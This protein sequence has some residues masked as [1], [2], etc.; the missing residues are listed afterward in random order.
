MSDNEIIEIFG[1]SIWD[2]TPEELIKNN[3]DIIWF[4]MVEES[5]V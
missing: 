1:K 3:L 2:M 5:E 4:H